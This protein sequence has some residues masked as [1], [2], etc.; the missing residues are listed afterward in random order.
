MLKNLNNYMDFLKNSYSIKADTFQN[1]ID[2]SS[3]LL[4]ETIFFQYWNGT[5]LNIT[6]AMHLSYIGSPAYIHKKII[7][8]LGADLINLNHAQLN[9]KTKYIIPTQSTIVFYKKIA[10]AYQATNSQ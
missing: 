8:L 10:T 2:E 7:Q 9:K 4:L 5:P 1:S 3:L 6:K